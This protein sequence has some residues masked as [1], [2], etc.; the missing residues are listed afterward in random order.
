[1]PPSWRQDRTRPERELEGA[2]VKARAEREGPLPW[3]TDAATWGL[4]DSPS[5]LPRGVW[6]APL[7]A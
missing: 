2:E 6:P 5:G 7:C 4:N 1:M 3:P